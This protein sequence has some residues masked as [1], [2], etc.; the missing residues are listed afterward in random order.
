MSGRF[1]LDIRINFFSGRVVRL[2]REVVESPSLEVFKK[3]ADVVL[4][5]MVSGHGGDTLMVGIDNLSGLF[6]SL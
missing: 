1:R 4:R 2:P 5:H 6:Q 3:W